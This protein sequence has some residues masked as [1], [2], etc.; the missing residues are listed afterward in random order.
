MIFFEFRL[1]CCLIVDMQALMH[2]QFGASLRHYPSF[3]SRATLVM[4]FFI[5]MF[6]V[7]FL[8]LLPLPVHFPIGQGFPDWATPDFAKKALIEVLTK[9]IHKV[10]VT[11][12]TVL[13]IL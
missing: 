13:F 3:T 5:L 7:Y 4:D 1:S 6:N 11:N 2:Q 10:L 8:Q 12:S 9:P